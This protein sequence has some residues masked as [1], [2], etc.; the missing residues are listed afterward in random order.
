[1]VAPAAIVRSKLR[2]LI[3]AA[4]PAALPV[5]LSPFMRSPSGLPD[6]PCVTVYPSRPECE[7][8]RDTTGSLLVYY[9]TV[10]MLLIGK[11]DHPRSTSAHAAGTGV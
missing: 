11:V 7:V 8:T 10:S 6:L 2:R 5:W 9:D 4:V 1:M 3:A